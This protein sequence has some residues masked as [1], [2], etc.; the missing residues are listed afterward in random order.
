MTEKCR[1]SAP[2]GAPPLLQLRQEQ[3]ASPAAAAAG[4]GACTA[5]AAA[6]AAPAPA[7]LRQVVLLDKLLASLRIWVSLL[8]LPAGSMRIELLRDLGAYIVA[9]WDR[10]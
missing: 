10:E 5:V 3:P 9:A 1:G 8:P 2:V 7:P 4:S 6:A